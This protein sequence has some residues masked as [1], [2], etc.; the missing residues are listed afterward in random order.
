MIMAIP[1]AAQRMWGNGDGNT[2]CWWEFKMDKAGFSQHVRAMGP[3]RLIRILRQKSWRLFSLLVYL[4]LLGKPTSLSKR[5]E[6]VKIQTLSSIGKTPRNKTH[7]LSQGEVTTESQQGD[8]Y[9]FEI[10]STFS[11]TNL[12]GVSPLV[13][14]P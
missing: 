4:Y 12:A 5:R 6:I 9:T 13:S 2:H 11:F 10:C 8:Q 7:L 14:S 1:N 3:R